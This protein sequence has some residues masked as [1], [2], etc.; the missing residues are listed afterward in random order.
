LQV[1]C[2]GSKDLI[3]GFDLAREGDRLLWLIPV[4]MLVTVM[5]GLVRAVWERVPVLFAMAG[6]VA[7]SLSAYI[8]YNEYSII[9]N[10]PRLAATQWTPFFWCAFAAS[11]GVAVAAFVFYMR[12]ARSP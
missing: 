9:N 5:L 12:R 10:S 2:G 1:G 3:S 4:L 6:T 11:L 8:M 7:G